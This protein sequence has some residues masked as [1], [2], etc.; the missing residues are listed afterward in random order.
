M[1]V[2]VNECGS[3]VVFVRFADDDLRE[4]YDRFMPLDLKGKSCEGDVFT[5]LLIILHTKRKANEDE[6]L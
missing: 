5:F 3:T 6:R 1:A 4:V 2:D